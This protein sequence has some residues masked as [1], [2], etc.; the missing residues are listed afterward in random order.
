[1]Q[2]F[3]IGST[4]GFSALL[5]CLAMTSTAMA[6]S[7]KC[8]SADGKIEYSDRPC[9]T[10]KESLTQPRSAGGVVATPT[11]APKVRLDALF[12]D[13]ETRLCEREKLATEVDIAQRSGELKKDEAAW[14]PRQER[15]SLLNDTLIEFQDKAGKITK[16]TASDSAEMMAVRSFQRKLKDCS[17][18]KK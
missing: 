12:T 11:V 1:M 8:K 17:A 10:S 4:I 9:D 3:R 14:K 6:D 5:L 13:Y 16:G 18:V 15:L 2:K 7:Y